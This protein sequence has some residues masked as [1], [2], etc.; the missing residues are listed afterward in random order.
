MLCGTIHSHWLQNVQRDTRRLIET[1]G[2]SV[3]SPMFWSRNCVLILDTQS[4]GGSFK[5]FK[6]QWGWGQSKLDVN[7]FFLAA[8]IAKFW[9][10]RERL[11]D[12][13]PYTLRWRQGISPMA[14]KD[15]G[16]AGLGGG[17]LGPLW[18]PSWH[19]H[20]LNYYLYL[21]FSRNVVDVSEGPSQWARACVCS[22]HF[23]AEERTS[24]LCLEERTL[25]K[26]PSR[27]TGLK[28]FSNWWFDRLPLKAQPKKNTTYLVSQWVWCRAQ[29]LIC[30]CWCYTVFRAIAITLTGA[31]RKTGG[32]GGG[33]QENKTWNDCLWPK[34]SPCN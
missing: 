19:F 5:R 18:R 31:F 1:A 25:K 12:F 34:Q 4:S 14:R 22:S 6:L 30:L 17:A 33:K 15:T 29:R 24:P 27:C 10:Y 20:Q 2:D 16:K 11:R 21:H 8:N 26:S 28:Y 23:K 13:L 32:G 9:N 3:L 7:K